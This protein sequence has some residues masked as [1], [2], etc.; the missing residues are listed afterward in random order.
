V[1]LLIFIFGSSASTL[2]G[3][4]EW[5]RNQTTLIL[6]NAYLFLDANRVAN[7][8]VTL[9]LAF[10][11]LRKLDTNMDIGRISLCELVFSL[12]PFSWLIQTPIK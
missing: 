12:G 11:G 7:L 2:A 5:W 8:L 3:V 10:G 6:A 9:I 4:V 1:K